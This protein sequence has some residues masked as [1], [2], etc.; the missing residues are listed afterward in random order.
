MIA[1]L[2]TA[3]AQSG[4]GFLVQVEVN[5]LPGQ[6][7]MQIIG[8]GDSSVKE[9]KDRIRSAIL[10]SGFEF[11]IKNIVVNLAPND[12]PK[13]GSLAEL[14]IAIGILIV[15]GQCPAEP[16]NNTML[17]GSL[18]LDGKLQAC[19]G[20]FMASILAKSEPHIT[21]VL[22]PTKAKDEIA[23][24]PNLPVFALSHLK[25][26]KDYILGRS[27]AIENK[28]F[29]TENVI[30]TIDMCNIYGQHTAK[31]AL[32]YS[33][34]GSHH[35]ILFGTPGSGKTMLANAFEGL[36]PKLSLEESLEITTIYSTAGKIDNALISKR[37]IRSP[38]HT[39][40]EIAMV[41]GGIFLTPGEI[42]LAHKGVLFLDE[43]F[44]FKSTTLQALREPLEER[45]I[46]ISRSKGT[47]SFPADFIF[48]AASNPCKCGYLFSKVHRCSCKKSTI[49]E[50]FQ[51][52]SGPFEDRISMEV[53]M[54][55]INDITD[56]HASQEKNSA[57]WQ[58]KVIEGRNRMLFRNNGIPNSQLKP[59]A[60]LE[61]IHKVPNSKVILKDYA[62]LFALSHRSFMNTL[63]TAISIQDFNE[64]DILTQ[65]HIEEAFKY[66]LFRKLRME[67]QAVA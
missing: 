59:D 42:S 65:E 10:N 60:L 49:Y 12:R 5:M 55:E 17:L 32:S 53:E 56:F 13:I 34:I 48:L 26:I 46:T 9:S 33:A 40:S 25:D 3:T 47:V 45:K 44:E 37:P 23:S 29:I 43:L 20:I 22:I 41:G 7:G 30:P 1:K 11:P 14:A 51:K 15:S 62:R 38:H 21:Q 16:F 64:T 35:T 19:K 39:T 67:Y 8:L 2:Y 66:R 6:M 52:I 54:D 61:L 58:S 50:L 27:P 4:G 31:K 24:I 28:E 18:S 36:L 57:W 63:K